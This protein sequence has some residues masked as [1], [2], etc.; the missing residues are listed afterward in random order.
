MQSCSN[1]PPEL[2]S[3]IADRL[4]LIELVCFRSYCKAWNSAS[5]AASAKIESAL[6]F[7]PWFLLYGTGDEKIDSGQICKLVA[8]CS[9]KFNMSLPELDGATCLASHQG[10][11]LL[12]KE[13]QHGSNSSMFFFRPFSKTK[14]DLSESPIS[15]VSDH[16]AAFSCHPISLDCTI[17]VTGRINNDELEVNV[18]RC[19]ANK[20][21]QVN[22][23]STRAMISTTECNA[24]R[25]RK[26]GFYFLDRKDGL[27][28]VPISKSTVSPEVSSVTDATHTTSKAEIFSTYKKYFK[29]TN[30]KEKL[31]I[32]VD[33]DVSIS[34]CGTQ[35]QEDGNDT[36]IYNETIPGECK[37]PKYKG[38]WIYP[39]F[40][41]IYPKDQSW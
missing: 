32:A 23:R 20:W 29:S 6:D 25:T 31:G 17:C 9:T 36:F 13:G 34:T 1:L 11:L 8:D 18:L 40:Y 21:V 3:M 26:Q 10:W 2:L 37:S 24:Y 7:E 38:V 14:I 28:V 4:S 27:L 35:T 30:M 41:Q 5:S 39:K 22:I 16:V 33:E 12:F 15:K 19:E